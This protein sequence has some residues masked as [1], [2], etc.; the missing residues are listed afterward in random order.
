MGLLLRFWMMDLCVFL[1]GS[2]ISNNHSQRFKEVKVKPPT[3]GVLGE[4]VEILK[5][6]Y[7][8]RHGGAHV[9]IVQV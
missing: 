9:Y 1:L 2:V 6:W 3:L 4:A 5:H 8:N 7:L